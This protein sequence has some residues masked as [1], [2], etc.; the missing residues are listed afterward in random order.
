MFLTKTPHLAAGRSSR[1]WERR[2]RCPSST[3]W[4]LRERCWP[5]PRPPGARV[6]RASRWC[7]AR[8]AARRSVWRRTC[9][10]RRRLAASFDL[11]PSSMSPLE[12]FRDYLTIVSNTDVRNAEAFEA[13]GDRRR[14]LPVERGL[15][16]AGTSQA[17]GRLGR[18]RRRVD[19]PAL[20]AAVRPGHADAVDAA[21][22]RERRSVRRVRLRLR[23]RLHRH[24]QLG[25]ADRAAADGA[26]PARRVRHAVR[27]RRHAR[28]AGSAPAHQQAASSTG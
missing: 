17:D 9:G 5:R 19:G 11:T 24:D 16:D 3:R 21:V 7:T 6:C 14:S 20:R 2:S 28:T 18:L 10:R 1:R 13:E 27:R 25:G 26:R 8:L 22:H 4:C 12:P 23:L 15:P